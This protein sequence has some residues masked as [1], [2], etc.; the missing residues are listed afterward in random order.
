MDIN[1]R[2][3]NLIADVPITI[4]P[5]PTDEPDPAAVAARRGNA[6]RGNGVKRGLSEATG[7]SVGFGF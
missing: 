1:V 6:V 3:Q 4:R 2:S 5:P 7:S